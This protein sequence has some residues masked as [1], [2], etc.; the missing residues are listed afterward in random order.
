MRKLAIAS[1]L[2]L[3]I[4]T[5]GCATTAPSTSVTPS[6]S[7]T[8]SAPALTE[9]KTLTIIS[10]ESFSLSDELK[11]KFAA[12]TGYEVNYIAPG[13]AGTVMNQLILSKDAPL[14]DVVFGIDNTLAGQAISEG[15][16]SPYLPTALPASVSKLAADQAGSLTAIDY[17]DVC[18]NADKN[19]YAEKKL[20]IPQTLDDLA[21]PEYKDQLVV[22]NPASSSPG[23]A[24]L[25]GTIA[26]KGETGYLDYWKALKDNGVSVEAG[27]S[28]AYYTEFS[29]SEG[30]GPRPL[31][32]SYASSPMYETSEGKESPTQAL[33]ATCVR[34]V[35]YAGIIKGAQNEVGA[36]KFIDF[37][38]STEV[39]TSIPETMYMSPADDSVTLPADWAKYT[40]LVTDPI[41]IDSATVS[42]QRENW[43][44]AWTET[45]IG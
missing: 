24:F 39:Q 13:G 37:L 33:V 5:I 44:T 38:I 29:G 22:T 40:T 43:I 12:D 9:S 16:L 26:E 20:A 31:V 8:P 6:E 3:L 42:A 45:V 1:S 23:L 17:G 35:E 30:K 32:L 41:M 28:E 15:I 19:W 21:K 2:L 18:L 36:R 11:A 7:S 27:W 10:H 25:A 34:Q 4:S 14:G